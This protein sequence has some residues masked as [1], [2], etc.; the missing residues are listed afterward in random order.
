MPAG[1]PRRG[2]WVGPEPWASPRL[3]P[4]TPPLSGPG[5]WAQMS[6]HGPRAS[7]GHAAAAETRGPQTPKEPARL[8][9]S[10]PEGRRS[11]C[12]APLP[13]TPPRRKRGS[14]RSLRR[15][16]GT[17]WALRARGS[18][19]SW[20]GG[21]RVPLS[22][23]CVQLEGPEQ[24]R[25]RGEGCLDGTGTGSGMRPLRAELRLGTCRFC[26]HRAHLG[27]V[28]AP[29]PCAA[30]HPTSPVG[31]PAVTRVTALGSAARGGCGVATRRVDHHGRDLVGPSR[32]PQ[33]GVRCC[34]VLQNRPRHGRHGSCPSQWSPRPRSPA[35][36]SRL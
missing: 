12:R 19:P 21:L 23:A 20:A 27:D 22:F 2:P 29:R 35:H 10:Q 28:S 24:N 4:G 34:P 25:G 3:R 5:S 33:R 13:H 14:L 36:K 30:S 7:T 1:A 9:S 17:Q 32:P 8:S 11:L 31:A 18:S 15:R 16:W 26:P 6:D